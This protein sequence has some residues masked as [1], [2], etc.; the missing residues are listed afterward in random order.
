MAKSQEIAKEKQGQT[1]KEQSTNVYVITAEV[2]YLLSTGENNDTEYSVDGVFATLEQA[3]KFAN[4]VFRDKCKA[5]VKDCEDPS[6]VEVRKHTYNKRYKNGVVYMRLA[7]IYGLDAD[8][9]TD[10]RFSVKVFEVPFCDI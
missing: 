5:I 8:V 7:N 4:C 6:G 1:P 10:A 2:T 3:K 9:A